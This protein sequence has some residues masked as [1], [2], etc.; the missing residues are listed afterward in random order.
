MANAVLQISAA[1]PLK[2]DHATLQVRRMTEREMKRELASYY[3][4][5]ATVQRYR[6]KQE[7]TP[8]DVEAYAAALLSQ[9][10]T[11][12]RAEFRKDT[13]VPESRPPC[14]SGTLHGD[15]LQV[16]AA[17]NA[18]NIAALRRGLDED[19]ALRTDGQIC[20]AYDALMAGNELPGIVR[21]HH[22]PNNER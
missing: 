18:Q 22:K 20:R 7:L 14:A 9:V 1:A 15:G 5:G 16:L 10:R 11:F 2:Y 17:V 12:Q 6:K 19:H 8:E 3:Q 4:F 13:L 21:H